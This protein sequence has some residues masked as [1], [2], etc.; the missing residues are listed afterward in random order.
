MST[1]GRS[2]SRAVAGYRVRTDDT[3]SPMASPMITDGKSSPMAGH[4]GTAPDRLCI[5][6]GEGLLSQMLPS[7]E[8]HDGLLGGRFGRAETVSLVLRLASCSGW[9]GAWISE[10][11]S[12]CARA[13]RAASG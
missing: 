3:S 13:Q 9:G 4:Q 12:M 6:A 8:C 7:R 1:P 5:P 10:S 2:H 11:P